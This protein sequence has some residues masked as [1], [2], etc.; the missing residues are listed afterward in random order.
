MLHGETIAESTGF[1]SKPPIDPFR[2]MRSE[3][4]ISACGLDFGEAFDGRLEY[5]APQFLLFYNTKYDAWPHDGDHHP[6]V[7]FTV[8]HE[9]GHFF[10][11][12]HREYLRRGGG[13]HRSFS[14]F[15]ADPVVEQ[16]ADAF[17]AG[18]LMPSYLLSGIV[19]EDPA[20]TLG[21]L[22]AT[23]DQFRVSLTSMMVRWVQLSHFPCA[24]VAV[25]GS[26]RIKWGF[27]SE[28]FVEAGVF[29]ARVGESVGS[30]DTRQ[31]ISVD[32][33]VS[34]YREGQG[35]GLVHQW[36]QSDR[37][38]IYVREFQ[39]AIPYRRDVLVLVTADEDEVAG[40]SDDD[41]RYGYSE[42]D[43]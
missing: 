34:R 18:L 31:F 36:L 9:L 14:E 20:P 40:A 28:A 22:K 21:L 13:P 19:N 4:R 5:E 30:S 23:R 41:D 3:R 7:R 24:A 35:Q 29:R 1:F 15:V 43:D 11:D 12:E 32:P 42:D 2:I 17:A 37:K 26:G 10:I 38:D 39:V 25:S 16:Q 27:V 33:S 8:G 6:K